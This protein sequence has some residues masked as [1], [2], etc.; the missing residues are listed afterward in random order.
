MVPSTCLS[1]SC[2]RAGEG[3]GGGGEHIVRTCMPY[4]HILR[5]GVRYLNTWGKSDSE[6]RSYS[7][8]FIFQMHSSLQ[9]STTRKPV[10]GR[11]RE[12][13]AEKS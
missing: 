10:S 5:F 2:T 3:G 4:K 1:T 8:D 9:I 7:R 12:K 13:F 11:A 6:S